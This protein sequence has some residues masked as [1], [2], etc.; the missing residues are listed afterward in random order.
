M[1]LK[2]STNYAVRIVFYLAMTKKITTSKEL[3]DKLSMPQSTVLKI[4][5]KLSENGIISITTGMQGGFLLRKNPEDITIFDVIN[6]FEPTTKIN[7][8]LE[9]DKYCDG[10]ATEDCPVR[11]V[12]C[13]IQQRFEND[14]KSTSI[15]DLL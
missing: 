3:S 4:G 2:V 12:Y 11:K 5:K 6:L 10:F 13:K 1:Q 7:R 8:C 15:K 9:E 14:L